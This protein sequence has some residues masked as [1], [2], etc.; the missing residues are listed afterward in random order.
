V[1]PQGAADPIRAITLDGKFPSIKLVL[2]G[3]DDQRDGARPWQAR[4][5]LVLAKV[6]G[7]YPRVI[8]RLRA[9]IHVGQALVTA[10]AWGGESQLGAATV[11]TSY[12]C[13]MRQSIKLLGRSIVK[14]KKQ[15]LA[16]PSTAFDPNPQDLLRPVLTFLRRSGLSHAEL[17]T[18]IRRALQ[19]AERG[20]KS[21]KVTRIG[22]SYVSSSI[23]NRWL[24]DPKY[25]SSRGRPVD[26]AIAG[27]G[28]NITE[29]LK[30]CD[31]SL[32]PIKAVVLLQEFGT[33]K[34]LASGH[35]RLVRRFLN[36]SIPEHLPFEPNFRFLVDAA[37]AATRGL[38]AGTRAPRLFWHCADSTRVHRRHLPEFLQFAQDKSLSFMLEI[39]DWLEQHEQA[40]STKKGTGK[41]LRRIGVGLFGISSDPPTP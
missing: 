3:S 11:L 40:I 14:K 2:A 32:T 24:R 31:V 10:C 39:N 41:G 37:A 20:G 8:N 25:L 9:E 19:Q 21:L 23:V 38:G 7:A 13:E 6:G 12:H 5:L 27:P 36:F 29:L 26:L 22:Y 1:V 28:P 16:G 17:Q 30:D 35:F 34:K 15:V 33:I 18:H 4:C